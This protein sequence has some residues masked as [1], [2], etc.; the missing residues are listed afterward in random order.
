M[1]HRA[2]ATR[3]LPTQLSTFLALSRAQR[4]PR[5]LSR[6]YFLAS[7]SPSIHTTTMALPPK[8]KGH[9]LVFSDQVGSHPDSEPL[10][11][12]E[13]YLDYVCPFSASKSSLLPSPSPSP[14]SPQGQQTN[15]APPPPPPE[16]NSSTPSSRPSRPPCA[17]A[18]RSAHACR[19]SSGRRCSRGTRRARWRTRRG[20]RCYGARRS[21]SGPS[22][23][24]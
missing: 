1:W 7:K 17:P 6:H 23:R 10:H 15:P 20:W 19:C 5:V 11:T 2:A 13:L 22:A 14:P 21:A 24:R 18:P 9:R 12:V 8:F 16:Q 4:N 3:S